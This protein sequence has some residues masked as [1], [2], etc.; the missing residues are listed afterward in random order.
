MAVFSSGAQT[1]AKGRDSVRVHPASHYR[2]LKEFLPVRR[3]TR[4][5]GVG[6]KKRRVIAQSEHPGDTPTRR[7]V[8][9]EPEAVSEPIRNGPLLIFKGRK[10]QP[11][12]PY[13][14]DKGRGNDKVPN[15]VPGVRPPNRDW[16]QGPALV[17][18]TNP[19]A[20]PVQ[21]SAGASMFDI[22]LHDRGRKCYR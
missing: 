13:S 16:T 7:T 11:I 18:T 2:V 10:R 17:S 12:G 9:L 21:A 19:P 22:R 14:R 6:S 1:R 20:L 15:H 3:Q 4:W 5:L 8:T